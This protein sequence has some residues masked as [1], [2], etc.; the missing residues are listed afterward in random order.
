MSVHHARASGHDQSGMQEMA[1]DAVAQA[2]EKAEELKGRGGERLRSEVDR[3]STDAGEQ[4]AQLADALRK[5]AHELE[6]TPAT[7]A[8]RAADRIESLGGYLRAS[9]ADRLLGDVE[10]T[11]RE[12]PWLAGGVGLVA[13]FVASRFLKASSDRRYESAQSARVDADLPMQRERHG[14]ATEAAT[15]VDEPTR[16]L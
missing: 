1:Q 12:R 15:F 6:G 7:L 13:G 5:S 16:G 14:L 4:A 3:R 9:D 10:R 8:Y 2:Q 11:A